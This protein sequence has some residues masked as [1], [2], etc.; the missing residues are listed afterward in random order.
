MRIRPIDLDLR[1]YWKPDP[2]TLY[3]LFY[4]CFFIRLLLKEL[5]TRKRQDLKPFLVVVSIELS[6]LLVIHRR[7]TSL[8]RHIDNDE[9]LDLPRILLKMH[10]LSIDVPDLEFKEVVEFV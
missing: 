2:V 4:L 9:H 3:S 6:Q 5:I 10:N 8:S 7:E 1:K